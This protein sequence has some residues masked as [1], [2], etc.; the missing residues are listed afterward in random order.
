MLHYITVQYMTQHYR[1][2]ICTDVHVALLFTD[3]PLPHLLFCNMSWLLIGAHACCN[4][5]KGGTLQQA[6][7]ALDSSRG[8]Q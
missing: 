1:D 2:L 5:S 3:S 8:I 4:W 7:L 6:A